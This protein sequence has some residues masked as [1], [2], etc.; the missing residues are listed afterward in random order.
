MPVYGS[1]IKGRGAAAW[2]GRRARHATAGGGC[3]PNTS[4]CNAPGNTTN[5]AMPAAAMEAAATEPAAMKA[6]A[7]EAAAVEA[8]AA[9]ARM[10]AAAE[11]AMKEVA[12]TK[13]AVEAAAVAPDWKAV[14]IIGIGIV[15][16]GRRVVTGLV[17]LA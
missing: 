10:E 7:V 9:E 13:A 4:A 15:V 6:A 8:A 17:V 11:A 12:A 3:G 2:R 1:R 16:A 5:S 14:P